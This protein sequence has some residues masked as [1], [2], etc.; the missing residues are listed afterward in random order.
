MRASRV[1]LRNLDFPERNYALMYNSHGDPKQVLKYVII[2]SI[3]LVSLII[4]LDADA[5]C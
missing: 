1:I 3:N 5:K 2:S 4:N